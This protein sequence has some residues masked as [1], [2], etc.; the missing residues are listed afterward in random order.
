MTKASGAE[1]AGEQ[2]IILQQLKAWKEK[3]SWPWYDYIM[4]YLQ[5]A[6]LAIVEGLTEFLPISSTAHLVFAS[7]V[8]GISQSEFVKTF[9]IAIQLGAI[10]AIVSLYLKKVWGKWE[11]A[12]KLAAAFIPTGIIGA[13]VYKFVKGT[14]IGNEWVSIGALFLGGFF[15][16]AWEKYGNLNKSTTKIEELPYKKCAGIGVCQSISMI[17]GI[18][19]AAATIFGGMGMGLSRQEA[20]EMSFLL[21]VPTMAAA[22]GYDLLKSMGEIGSEQIGLLAWG[23][24]IA[25]ITA[26]AVVKWLVKFV[27]GHKMTVFGWYRIAMATAW[28][29]SALKLL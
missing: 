23:G 13:L 26:L 17:P 21:A 22:T 1:G 3:M 18:S 11:L 16:I 12:K 28:A 27:Q 6:A 25:W 15:I 8:M 29:I 2:A 9:E 19:R 10:M 24:A 14:L 4:N 5:A 20:V 7:Q